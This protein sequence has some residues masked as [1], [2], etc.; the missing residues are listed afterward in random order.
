MKCKRCG[1]N[2][3]GPAQKR[4]CEECIKINRRE[5]A[6][7]RQRKLREE[8]ARNMH[9]KGQSKQLCQDVHDSIVAGISYGVYMARK[10]YKNLW[11]N[12]RTKREIPH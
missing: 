12:R 5:Y 9:I 6:R 11:V 4:F 1:T 2:I 7:N 8:A 3:K 10:G